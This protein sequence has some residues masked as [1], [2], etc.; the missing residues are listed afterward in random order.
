[1]RIRPLAKDWYIYELG[2][3]PR[4]FYTSKHHDAAH[5]WS[6]TPVWWYNVLLAALEASEEKHIVFA[7]KKVEG[8]AGFYFLKIPIGYF[9]DHLRHF[10]LINDKRINLMLSAEE[11]YSFVDVRGP[12]MICFKQF[13]L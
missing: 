5:S 3:V 1:M 4:F 10:A 2:V 8:N 12:G 7:A 9:I 13:L 11:K 6:R